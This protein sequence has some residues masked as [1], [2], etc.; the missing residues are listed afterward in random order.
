MFGF[1]LGRLRAMGAA[2]MLGLLVACGGGGGG[3]AGDDGGGATAPTIQTQP[4]AVAVTAGQPATFTVAAGGDAPLS[5]QWQ[6]DGVA[7]AGATAAS[8]TLPAAAAAD[9]GANFRVVVSNAAGSATSDA[10]TLTVTAVGAGVR[11]ARISAGFYH[12]LAVR[13]DGRVL[14]WGHPF[15]IAAPGTALAG[16]AAVQLDG[17]N[18]VAAVEAAQSSTPSSV[19]LRT[20]GSV[21]QW[22]YDA[23]TPAAV[24]ALGSAAAVAHLD[25]VPGNTFALTATGQLRVRNGGML[26]GLDSVAAIR[27]DSFIPAQAELVAIKADGTLWRASV[28]SSGGAVLSQSVVQVTGVPAVKDASCSSGGNNGTLCLAVTTGGEVYAWGSSNAWGQFGNGVRDNAGSTL[29]AAVPG[30]AGIAHV[31][32]G[33]GLALALAADGTLYRWGFQPYEQPLTTPTAVTGLPAKVVEVSASFNHVIVLL[34]DGTV[35]GWGDNNQGQLGDGTTGNFR[36]SP[37][38]ALGIDLD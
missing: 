10:A 34:D 19:A 35:W 4:Q 25:S 31:L 20:D 13:A 17:L 18:G 37:V 22:S 30:L 8:Y 14:A 38:R 28:L 27:E 7:I 12:T 23:T 15:Y 32:A 6:R 9:T 3:S 1:G 21:W 26:S 5:Y 11:G 24:P 33:D 16:T 2:W 29:P 36:T